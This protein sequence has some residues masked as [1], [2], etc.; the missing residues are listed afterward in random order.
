M[1]KNFTK[2]NIPKK[3]AERREWIKFQL[4]LRGLTLCSLGEKAGYTKSVL[5][6]ALGK[7]YP[8]A[9]AVIASALG[10]TPQ[11]LWPERYAKDGKPIRHSPRYPRKGI[12]RGK[13]PRN[14][15]VPREVFHGQPA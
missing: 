4:T 13:T 2:K 12:S 9:E 10:L 3:P 8:K 14:V 6:V 5:S 15:Y 11:E 1:Y 7:A